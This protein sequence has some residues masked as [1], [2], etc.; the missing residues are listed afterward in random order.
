MTENVISKE[1][2]KHIADLARLSLSENELNQLADELSE[3]ISHINILSELSSRLENLVETNQVSGLE[4][5]YREDVVDQRRALSQD[6]ALSNGK[7]K[8]KGYFVV[9]AVIET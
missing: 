3:T 8:Y 7:S 9:S 6:E 5:V 2:L 4:N 1:E